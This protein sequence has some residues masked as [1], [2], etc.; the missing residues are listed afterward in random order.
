ML[1]ILREHSPHD[2]ETVSFS[3]DPK[4]T[5]LQNFQI[6]LL[7]SVISTKLTMTLDN[8]ENIIFDKH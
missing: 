5:Q 8:N 3:R 4:F 2:N 7:L 1:G 6:N